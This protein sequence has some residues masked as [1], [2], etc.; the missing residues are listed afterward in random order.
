MEGK[1]PGTGANAVLL[2]QRGRRK[3]REG[4]ASCLQLRPLGEQG[5]A[6]ARQAPPTRLLARSDQARAGGAA[7][8][9]R[10]ASPCGLVVS[11]GALPAAQGGREASPHVAACD[12]RSVSCNERAWSV[13]SAGWADTAVRPAP[14]EP[15]H[16]CGKAPRALLC[17]RQFSSR[18]DGMTR[19]GR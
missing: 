2:G 19:K 16:S 17:V 18:L 15:R 1:S 9:P 7:P 11:G 3:E 5:S 12:F 8:G 4:G 13:D 10:P 14:S 6:R